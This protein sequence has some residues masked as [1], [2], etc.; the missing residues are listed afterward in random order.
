MRIPRFLPGLFF[1]TTSFISHPQTQPAPRME[2]GKIVHNAGSATV[3]AND[4]RALA[5]AVVAIRQEYGWLVDYEDPIYSG[6]ELVDARTLYKDW[7]LA[8]PELK[9]GL[10]AAGGPFVS[11]YAESFDPAKST[12]A[13]RAAVLMQVL[14]DY[15]KSGYAGHFVLQQLGPRRLAVIGQNSGNSIL[16]TT[17][18]IDFDH[19]PAFEALENM[20]HIVGTKTGY[21]VGLGFVPNNPLMQCIVTSSFRDKTARFILQSVL[22]SCSLPLTWQALHGGVHN[23][24]YLVNLDSAVRVFTDVEGNRRYGP[25]PPLKSVP[26]CPAAVVE[27]P[28]PDHCSPTPPR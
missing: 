9:S 26:R 10:V 1:L 6:S 3:Q 23:S 8:H 16:S 18:S 12:D 19:T 11:T 13:D 5:Q 21:R 22:D 27:S 20:L 4:S 25:P 17:I 2:Y 28:A 24:F 14:S 15:A 7:F